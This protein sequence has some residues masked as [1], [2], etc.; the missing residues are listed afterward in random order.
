MPDNDH[1]SVSG[2]TPSAEHN[3]TIGSSNYGSSLASANINPIVVT[4]ITVS[5]FRRQLSFYRPNKKLGLREAWRLC[6]PASGGFLVGIPSTSIFCSSTGRIS[7]N[8]SEMAKCLFF[9]GQIKTQTGQIKT[10]CLRPAC[11]RFLGFQK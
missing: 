4:S 9:A 1:E 10:L 5:E 6:W 8:I 7:E 2:G 3:L 11:R